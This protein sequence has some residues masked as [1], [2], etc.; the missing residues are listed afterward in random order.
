MK[1]R[2]GGL[3]AFNRRNLLSGESDEESKDCLKLVIAST[4]HLCEFKVVL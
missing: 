1:G 2:E 3:G 4:L